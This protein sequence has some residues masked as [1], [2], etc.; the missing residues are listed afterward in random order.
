MIQYICRFELEEFTYRMMCNHHF[1][2]KAL[3]PAI[4]CI[5]HFVQKGL[6][7]DF[8]GQQYETKKAAEFSKKGALRAE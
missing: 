4:T 3:L 7:D 1:C 5:A 6:V 8:V 2:T